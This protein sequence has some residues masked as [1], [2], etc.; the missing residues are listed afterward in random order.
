MSCPFS[1]SEFCVIAFGF[2]QATRIYEKELGTVLL[3]F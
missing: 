3:N 2:I 1:V